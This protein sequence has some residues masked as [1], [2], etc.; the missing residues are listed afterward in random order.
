MRLP[1]YD[2]DVAELSD[3]EGDTN[4]DMLKFIGRETARRGLDFQLALWTQRYD[5]D[6][7]PRANYTVRH[8]S[9]PTWRRIAATPSTRLLTE[10]PEITG[11]TFRVHVEGGIA[12]GDYGFWREAF[13]GVAAAWGGRSRST[14]TA[15]AST[16]P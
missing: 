16:T 9:A 5:F 6:D 3:E 11:L 14:C 2:I 15:K 4:L 7:V 1:G 8:V 12:E 13:A 10:V